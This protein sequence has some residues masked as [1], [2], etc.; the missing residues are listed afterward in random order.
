MFS[1]FL[2]ENVTGYQPYMDVLA[3]VI[4]GHSERLKGKSTDDS[5]FLR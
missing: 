3:N 1:L 5:T 2:R 4:C